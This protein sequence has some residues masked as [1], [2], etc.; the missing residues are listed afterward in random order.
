AGYFELARQA[1]REVGVRQPFE[2]RELVL[3]APLAAAIDEPTSVQAVLTPTDFGYSLEVRRHL[4]TGWL[5][6]GEAQIVLRAPAPVPD[7]DL[8]SLRLHASQLA[9]TRTRQQDH[10]QLGPR[11]RVAH[12]VHTGSQHSI[13]D[14][15]L[16]ATYLGDLQGFALHPAL[17]DVG[18]CFALEQVPGYSGDAL[19]V[20][21]SA[22][23]VVVHDPDGPRDQLRRAT[24]I[25]VIRPTS[26]EVAG[27]ATFDVT[28]LDSAGR[29]RLS[30]QGFTM[31]RL[32]GE[33]ELDVAPSDAT[34]EPRLTHERPMTPAEE[35][36]R[37]SVSGG[38]RAQEGAEAFESALTHYAAI[39]L[40]V[41][42]FDLLE[43]QKSANRASGAS[44][45]RGNDSVVTFARPLLSSA[46]VAP[47]DAVEQTLADLWQELLG[48]EQVGVRD[49]FFD[50]GGHSLIAVR[51][52]ARIRKLFSV[53]LPMSALFGAETVETSAALIRALLPTTDSAGR[54]V[55]PPP[56][57]Y[58]YLVPMHPRDDGRTTPFFLV[59][60]MFGNVLNLRHLSNQIG[61]DRPFYGLQA[62]GLFG[63][64]VP[65]DS[66][67]EMAAAYLEEIRTV[68]PRGPY[69]L[70]GFSGGGVTALEMARQLRDAG[71]QVALL[72]LLDT[73]APS[74][75]SPLT[76]VDR[77][78]IQ[79]QDVLKHRLRYPRR[80][81][82]NR[83]D[84]QR[85]LS[86]R[87]QGNAPD[88]GMQHDLAIEAAF[89]RA[90]DKYAVGH[91]D[92]EITLY[93]PDHRVLYRLPG[94]R[95]IDERRD[96]VEA[97][98]GWRRHCQHVTTID[99]PGDHDSMVLE[100]HVRVLAAAL[101][102]AIE[103]AETETEI[104]TTRR[105]RNARPTS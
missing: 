76:T 2:L 69:L 53:D 75:R 74:L 49:S 70:G 4:A 11:W 98:N 77:A 14:L 71:E 7:P 91:F 58:R 30:V 36:F 32:T 12:Q 63:N 16:P 92:G 17:V 95:G 55:T 64:D 45:R 90:L 29:V 48:I 93:R 18:L 86:A 31:K 85:T 82:Q 94:G 87:Q 89:M 39:P 62:R 19:W 78:A 83:R 38:I 102:A 79:L 60:G 103:A 34:L 72:A 37:Y 24:V 88:T 15:E 104:E 23:S 6:T 3:P 40:A 68:Q 50:L 105:L 47:R 27:F 54:L 61:T 10:L 28:F 42:P 41:T 57:Q 33:L 97:D 46:F 43:L 13:A 44:L 65:H 66:F 96:F 80:W 25:A 101:R 21:V 81:L 84:W 99:V 100:P 5:R 67:E 59:A 52:F 22:Q 35:L 73:P 56:S 26:S 51:L 20:P 9:P 1:L 8:A